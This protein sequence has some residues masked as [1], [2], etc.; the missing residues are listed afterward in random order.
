[1]VVV[2]VPA[3]LLFRLSSF[4]VSIVTTLPLLPQP[5]LVVLQQLLRMLLLQAAEHEAVDSAGLFLQQLLHYCM[6][7][8][9]EAAA[10]AAAQ[11]WDQL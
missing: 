6:P 11:R 3:L 8:C 10:E 5:L 7:G 1:M 2:M 9:T 4:V